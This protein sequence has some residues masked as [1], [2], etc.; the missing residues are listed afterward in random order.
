MGSLKSRQCKDLWCVV[1]MRELCSPLCTERRTDRLH[2]V[3]DRSQLLNCTRR[4]AASA[5]LHLPTSR[6]QDQITGYAEGRGH[7][8]CT[9]SADSG[10]H[11]CV[12]TYIQIYISSPRTSG[13]QPDPSIHPSSHP[14]IQACMHACLRLFIQIICSFMHSFVHSYSR[15]ELHT[16]IHTDRGHT[17]WQIS[18]H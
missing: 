18:N 12:H 15:A 4:S 6:R 13:T 8:A 11:T 5:F 3:R 14:S 1:Q 2:H 16:Y 7:T 17:S 10:V 9:D